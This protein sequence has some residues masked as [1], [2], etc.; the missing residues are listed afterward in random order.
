[1]KKVVGGAFTANTRARAWI[2]AFIDNDDPVYTITKMCAQ[3]F[4]FLGGIQHDYQ[5][6]FSVML[7]FFALEST[8]D[9][10]RILLAFQGAHSLSDVV[11][12]STSLAYTV[13]GNKEKSMHRE[14]VQLKPS[15]VY[16]DLSRDK[17]VVIMVFLTQVILI[18]FVVCIDGSQ[19]CSRRYNKL[20]SNSHN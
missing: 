15:N 8:L 12:A 4:L 14:M 2:S 3:S 20:V 7:G 11:L 16:A 5:L 10:W 6:T 18:A 13:K 19:L 17:L 1:M 9:S